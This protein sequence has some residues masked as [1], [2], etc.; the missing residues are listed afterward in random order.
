MSH[1]QT[2]NHLRVMLEINLFFISQLIQFYLIFR[3]VFVKKK[4]KIRPYSY[5]YIFEPNQNAVSPWKKLIGIICFILFFYSF[6]CFFLFVL[7]SE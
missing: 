5:S 6:I 2:Q 3:L 4:K 7:F 1:E